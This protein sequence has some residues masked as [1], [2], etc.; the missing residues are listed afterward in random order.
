MKYI[1]DVD[2]TLTP[3]R[4][5]IDVNFRSFFNSFCLVN[6]V[7]LVTGSDKEK[8][9]EQIT[10]STYNLCKRVYQCAGNDVWEG[11]NNVYTNTL[12]VDPDMQKMFDQY[13]KESKFAARTGNHID[14]RPGLI[15]FSIVGRNATLA[16][17]KMYVAW[18]GVT[19]ERQEIA[20]NL[21]A[22]FDDFDCTVAG[23]TGIDIVP[24]GKDKA[25]ILKDFD[26]YKEL[27]FFGDKMEPGG[28][29]YT[30]GAKLAYG[31]GKITQV[32]GWEDTWQRLKS[33]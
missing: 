6:D 7:Y 17:R 9:V 13:L 5:I 15:N 14:V 27:H 2:G 4:G 1:F 23:E 24:K 20:D 11:N 25:Q 33:L 16:E 28:N 29:D 3:S 32:K 19:S 30:L 10:E 22:M 26:N 18:D 8:T 31:G 21:N 12:E